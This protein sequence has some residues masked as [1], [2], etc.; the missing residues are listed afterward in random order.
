MWIACDDTVEGGEWVRS[1]SAIGFCESPRDGVDAAGAR[2]LA[3]ELM[4]A[5]DILDP[6]GA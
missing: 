6:P 2:R 4:N 1:R 3:A 5:A